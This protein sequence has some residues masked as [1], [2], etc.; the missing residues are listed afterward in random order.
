MRTLALFIATSLLMSCERNDTLQ[1]QWI[2]PDSTTISC[3]DYFSLETKQGVLTNNV[4]NKHAAKKDPWE[5]CLEKKTINGEVHYGWS[6][7]WPSGRNV[8]YAQPQ[9][10]VGSSPWAPTPKLDDS[11]PLKIIG[12]SQLDIS[13]EIEVS[14]NGNHNT[15][16]T[17][18]LISE[19]Y[20]GKETNTDIIVAEIM[21]WTDSTKGHFDPAGQKL[22]EVK[23]ANN[24]WEV[25]YQKDW[26]D[27]S[28]IQKNKWTNV[29]FRLKKSSKK[30]FIPALSLLMF[31]VKKELISEDWY[32]ADIELGNEIMDGAG[33]T[34]I[35]EFSV[36]SQVKNHTIKGS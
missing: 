20:E 9:I 8:I 28:G 1:N 31:A 24:I 25:W 5:Q 11:F 16:I 13:H 4:W 35:K 30:A 29:S 26:S 7:S 2:K 34:W 6:W 23:I 18:W 21:F 32:I 15:A 33:I 3:Q 14:T 19:P 22:T 12:L 36:H 10:K 17:M 27:T